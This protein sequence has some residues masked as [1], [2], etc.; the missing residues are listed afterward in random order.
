M[1]P[2]APGG[3]KRSFRMMIVRRVTGSNSRSQF[4]RSPKT[5]LFVFR[6]RLFF[7]ESSARRLL[8]CASTSTSI[9]RSVDFTP[10]NS[11]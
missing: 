1:I 6:F 2:V 8:I 9:L 3:P 10:S 4:V 7:Q 11:R 5:G